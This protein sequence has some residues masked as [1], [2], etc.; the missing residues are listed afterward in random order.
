MKTVGVLVQKYGTF[1][2]K[3]WWFLGR[4]YCGLGKPIICFLFRNR[5]GYIGF[6]VVP[7]LHACNSVAMVLHVV[8][9]YKYRQLLKI[10]LQVICGILLERFLLSF[11]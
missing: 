11:D 2:C 9:R 10:A 5:G 4:E 7:M 1:G 3:V 6:V 8:F